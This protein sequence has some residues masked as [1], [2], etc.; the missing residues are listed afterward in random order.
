MAFGTQLTAVGRPVDDVAAAITHNERQPG[1]QDDAAVAVSMHICCCGCQRQH[2][3]ATP[4]EHSSH[5]APRAIR[6]LT[7][8]VAT[9]AVVAVTARQ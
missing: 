8:K 2:V 7:L 9:V 6:S 3:D 4:L 5:T 1:Q